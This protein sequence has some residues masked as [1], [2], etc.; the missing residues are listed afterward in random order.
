MSL[1]VLQVLRTWGSRR[2]I[3]APKR[4]SLP[5]HLGAERM[6][7]WPS[8]PVCPL[9]SPH[10]DHTYARISADSK[11]KASRWIEGSSSSR[12][13]PSPCKF[14]RKIQQKKMEKEKENQRNT[15]REQ[16]YQT[17]QHEPIP[18]QIK[19]NPPPILQER[20]AE[21]FNKASAHPQIHTLNWPQVALLCVSE[22]TESHTHVRTEMA[23]W[24]LRCPG[25]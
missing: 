3:R 17:V 20:T 19:P 16:V 6:E 9:P 15:E 14:W 21:P 12:R 2:L 24:V 7:Q 18:C 8:P 5:P 11:S 10:H 23:V 1:P 25:S 13:G 4:K 22:S